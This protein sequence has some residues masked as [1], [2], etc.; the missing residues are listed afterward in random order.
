MSY[1]E[2]LTLYIHVKGLNRVLGGTFIQ[3]NILNYLP[4]IHSFTFYI[5][6]YVDTISLSCKLSTEDIQRTLTNIGKQ[7]AISIVNYVSSDKAPC[8]IFSLPFAFDYLEHL[9]NAFPNIV[10][11]YVTYLLVED[12]NPFK[13]EFFI[14]IA[15]SFPLL[16]YLRIFNLESTAFYDLITSESVNSE[17]HTLNC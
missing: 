1:L 12:D 17:S 7:D 2:Q 8:S 4:Q 10:F 15:Q 9:G 3:D 14:R 16:K 13:H 6:S 5:G 11:S